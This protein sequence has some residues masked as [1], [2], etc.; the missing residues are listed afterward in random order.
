MQLSTPR[1]NIT[2]VLYVQ[3]LARSASVGAAKGAGKRLGPAHFPTAYPAFAV[4]TDSSASPTPNTP[5]P[6]E[7]DPLRAPA[8]LRVPPPLA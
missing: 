5:Y 8:N 2:P 1:E 7:T 4:V 6:L 3:P